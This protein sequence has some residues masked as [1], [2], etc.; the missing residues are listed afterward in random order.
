MAVRE[1]G[2]TEKCSYLFVQEFMHQ[3]LKLSM[4]F[5]L[6]T[7]VSLAGIV[8][9]L[10]LSAWWQFRT[11]VATLKRSFAHVEDPLSHLLSLLMLLY[12]VCS[13]LSL[14][15]RHSQNVFDTKMSIAK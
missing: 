10:L 15:P 7:D 4:C 8:R 3:F 11:Y 2:I 13:V 5:L 6:S 9:D 14:W 1:K 12:P